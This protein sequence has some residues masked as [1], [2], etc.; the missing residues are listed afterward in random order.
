MYQGH[1]SCVAWAEQSRC[2]WHAGIVLMR[3]MFAWRDHGVIVL[4]SL[5]AAV[6]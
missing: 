2:V 4:P 1:V 6:C 5:L 3:C